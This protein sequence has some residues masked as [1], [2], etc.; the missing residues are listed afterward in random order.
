MKVEVR[1][2][3]SPKEI[4]DKKEMMYKAE[5]AGENREPDLEEDCAIVSY[6]ELANRGYTCAALQNVQAF[7][8]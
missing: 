7:E 3:K 1:G 2:L 5:S 6:C 8:F 4:P